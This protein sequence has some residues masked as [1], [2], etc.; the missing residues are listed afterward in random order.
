MDRLAWTGTKQFKRIANRKDV[1]ERLG[2]IPQR[3]AMHSR[4]L[5]RE[6]AGLSVLKTLETLDGLR[7][8]EVGRQVAEAGS[9]LDCI[10]EMPDRRSADAVCFQRFI[11]SV[12]FPARKNIRPLVFRF[13]AEPDQLIFDV[14]SAGFLG[15]EPRLRSTRAG[16]PPAIAMAGMSPVTTAPAAITAPFPMVAPS[17]I[18]QLAPI[19]TSSPI[20]MPMLT[21]PW[22]CMGMV[23]SS[24]P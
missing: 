6:K 15:A 4:M 20:V 3:P 10:A 12:R 22:R 2:I 8:I 21:T 18:T 23:G 11:G 19:Q 17:R 7:R 16:T 13:L 5:F 14:A 24:K 1:I 9:D